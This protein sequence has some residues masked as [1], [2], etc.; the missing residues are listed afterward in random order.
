MFNHSSSYATR[1]HL[2]GWLSPLLMK[3]YKIGQLING[4]KVGEKHK[5]KQLVCCRPDRG[6]T[7]IEHDDK[8]MKLPDQPVDMIQFQDQYGRGSYWLNYYEWKPITSDT[9]WDEI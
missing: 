3:I 5:G 1:V 7:H 6:Y 9:M 4:F 2:G 8:I